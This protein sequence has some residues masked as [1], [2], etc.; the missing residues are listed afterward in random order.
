MIAL[1]QY[2]RIFVQ[3]VKL[4]DDLQKKGILKTPLD[5]DKFWKDFGRKSIEGNDIFK[6]DPLS[7]GMI[8]SNNKI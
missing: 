5:V 2:I 3:M 7:E 6:R 4:S 1:C 8:F